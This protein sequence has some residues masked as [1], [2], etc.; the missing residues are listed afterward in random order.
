MIG[1]MIEMSVQDP[2]VVTLTPGTFGLVRV[3]HSTEIASCVETDLRSADLHLP[4]PV[5]GHI[6]LEADRLTVVSEKTGTLDRRFDAHPSL[7]AIP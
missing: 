1:G 7:H 4:V 5:A 2:H 6:V 3:H